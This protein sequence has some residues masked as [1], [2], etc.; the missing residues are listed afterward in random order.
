M[1]IKMYAVRDSQSELFTPPMI[2]ATTR[3]AL[4]AFIVAVNDPKNKMSQHP[5][6]Y[7]FYEIGTYDDQIALLESFEQ[8]KRIALAIEHQKPKQSHNV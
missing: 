3:D 6:D 7:A 4:D 2:F 1:L 5:E 8:P